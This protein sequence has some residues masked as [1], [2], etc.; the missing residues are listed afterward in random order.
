M[1]AGSGMGTLEALEAAQREVAHKE[2]AARVGRIGDDIRAGSPVARAF[3]RSGVFAPQEV[4]LVRLGE[5][6]G[7]LSEH[8]RLVAATQAKARAFR[9]RVRSAFL[10]PAFVLG[11][12]ASV[13]IGM[14]W[15]V[16]PN[17]ALVFEQL[18]VDL[19]PVTRAMIGVG[20]FMRAEGAWAVPVFIVISTMVGYFAF[21]AP[22][23]RWIGREAVLALPGMRRFFRE[24]ETARAG[25]L[26]GS[27]MSAGLALPDALTAVGE[28]SESPRFRRMYARLRERV[29]AGDALGDAFDRSPGA[30]G[31]FPSSVRELLVAASRSGTLPET[32]LSVGAVYEARVETT[33]KN[34][35]VLLEP[36]L[37]VGVW[38][39]VL[40]VALS[41]ILP[42]YGLIGGFENA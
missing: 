27:L 18:R 31:A 32:F 10:Y 20:R 19:P 17:L 15:F 2:L 3:E 11:L 28:A 6:S 34:T 39:V 12:A 1:L 24:L 23:T 40:A 29:V 42:I 25:Y 9:S 5:Q 14:A 7:R 33:S 36:V 30:A 22:A 38:L 35:A 41:V 8:L 26:L 13:G 4:E 37:L 21:F 16:L